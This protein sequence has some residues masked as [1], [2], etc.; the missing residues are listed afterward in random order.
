[1]PKRRESASSFIYNNHVTLAG[2]WS[3]G[4]LNNMIQMNI[5]PVPDLTTNWS[6]FGAKLP[7]RMFGHSSVVYK[8]SLFVTGGYNADQ[9]VDSDCSHEVELKPPYTVKLL[10]KMPEPRDR[11]MCDDSILIVGGRNTLS[12]KDILSSV[13]RHDIKNNKY[14]QLQE[15]PYPVRSIPTVKWGENVVIIGGADKDGKALNK[16]I[17]YNMKTG[18]SHMLPPML[19]KRYGCS[20]VVIENT[21][22]ALGGRDERR[23]VLKSVEG[24]SFDRYTCEE[25]PDMKE[26]RAFATAT[27]I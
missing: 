16:V 11:H 6:D 5:H 9:D 19:H 18:N 2:G 4:S 8:D 24:F 12:S 25:L 1:M 10:A 20:A 14:Q 26:P 27:V 17:I 21:I 3:D 7:A 15:L 23:N 22:V 13:L